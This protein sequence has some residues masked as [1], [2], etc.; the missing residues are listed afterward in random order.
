[1]SIIKY[2]GNERLVWTR[3]ADP[4]RALYYIKGIKLEISIILSF[5]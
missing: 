5:K 4:F 1:M 3:T 2:V